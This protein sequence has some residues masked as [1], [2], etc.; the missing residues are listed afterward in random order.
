MSGRRREVE[1][2]DIL[3]FADRRGAL[4]SE[5]C[6]VSE[7]SQHRVT[8]LIAFTVTT[9]TW[10]RRMTTSLQPALRTAERKFYMIALDTTLLLL[11]Q[12]ISQKDLWFVFCNIF[13]S[14]MNGYFEYPIN[15]NYP[16]HQVVHCSIVLRT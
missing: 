1:S 8:P 7:R 13:S 16:G 6:Y 10:V 11:Q 9:C 14:F 12:T 3:Y 15:F 2:E 5:F 4:S